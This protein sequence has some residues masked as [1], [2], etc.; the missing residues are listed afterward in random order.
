MKNQKRRAGS[1]HE[2]VMMNLA[3]FHLLLP[4][5]ALSSGYVS[6]LL[7]LA[8]MGSMVMIFWAAYKV[9]QTDDVEFVQAHWKLAWKRYQLLLIAYA[10]SS[11]I[12]LLGWVLASL[13]TDHN[14]FSIMLVV[15]SR[16]AA[17]PIILM[18]LALFVMETTSLTKAKQGLFPEQ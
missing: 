11:V 15:F 9:R 7:S 18:V 5:A 8:L 13:Q 4:V 2:M 16:I 10:I 14:M 12:M 1:V 3:I 6:I 17:V